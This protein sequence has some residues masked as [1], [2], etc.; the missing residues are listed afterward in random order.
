MYFLSY[1]NRMYEPNLKPILSGLSDFELGKDVVV[2]FSLANVGKKDWYVLPWFTPLEGLMS[3]CVFVSNEGDDGCLEYH[4]IT[5]KRAAPTDEN[6]ILIRSGTNVTVELN[7]SKSYTFGTGR[8]TIRF[9]SDYSAFKCKSLDGV[10]TPVSTG[11]AEHT[12]YVR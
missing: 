8:H 2:Y 11:K 10:D 3:E 5:C 7:L 4:G 12:F 6:Y 1:N 9:G